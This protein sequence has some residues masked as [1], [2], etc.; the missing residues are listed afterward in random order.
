MH[1]HAEPAASNFVLTDTQT[2]ATTGTLAF[3]TTALQTSN[4]ASYPITGSGLT[5]NNGNYTF[6]QA[7]ANS[8]GP[9]TLRNDL[10]S[11]PAALFIRLNSGNTTV[12]ATWLMTK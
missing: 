11:A 7:P 1:D 4:A 3:N 9:R 12:P 6:S 5:A 10:L 8:T 2:N